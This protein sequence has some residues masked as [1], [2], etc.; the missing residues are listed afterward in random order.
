MIRL[1]WRKANGKPGL[2]GPRLAQGGSGASAR[3]TVRGERGVTVASRPHSLQSRLNSLLA[4]A[5]AIGIG[6]A[7][8]LWYYGEA[9]HGSRRQP[10]T[11]SSVTGLQGRMRLA[12]LGAIIVPHRAP[13]LSST[14]TSAGP[15]LDSEL[16]HKQQAALTD[17]DH[18]LTRWAGAGDAAP[19]VED[20]GRP[21]SRRRL[22]GPV[23]TFA[24]QGMSG[25]SPNLASVNPAHSAVRASR[26]RPADALTTLLRPAVLPATRA[27]LLPQQRLLLP[28][29]TFIDCTLETAIDSTL[30]GMSTCVTATDTFGADGTVVL[31]ERG[32]KLIGETRGE[33]P[34][35][36]SRVFILWSEARTPSGVVIRLDSPAT[37]ALGRSGLTG[38]VNRHFWQ[39]FGA[40]LL[41]SAVDGEV[42]SH[43][44]SSGNIVINPSTSEDVMT[45]AMR[46][47]VGIAPTISVPAGTRIQ[48]LVARDVDFRSVYDL[49]PR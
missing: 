41:V 25:S 36:S 7:M 12:Q 1:P 45:E 43:L 37:D 9:L 40:A 24:G 16:V 42:Q 8:L 10:M 3:E 14:L 48:V 32:T 33:V 31:L 26:G 18:S 11:D 29:G 39:R 34:Q 23:F 38:T 22:R 44:A 20:A 13:I 49:V 6:I 27:Q 28:K 30:P 17:R 2:G 5:L 46:S 35:G 15:P 4:V 21:L 47:T 19:A